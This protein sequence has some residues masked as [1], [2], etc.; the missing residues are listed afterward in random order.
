MFVLCGR[1]HSIHSVENVP[2]LPQVRHGGLT[3][4][5]YGAEHAKLLKLA[6]H[7]HGSTSAQL[8]FPYCG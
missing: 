4:P 1:H 3:V 7:T 6:A 8:I 5:P 2:K